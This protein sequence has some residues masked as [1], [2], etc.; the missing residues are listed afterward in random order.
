MSSKSAERKADHPWV[1][2][3]RR[4]FLKCSALLGGSLAA[5]TALGRFIQD[6][7]NGSAWAASNAVGMKDNAYV[8]H[9]PENQIHSVCQQC[10]TNCG[11]KVKIVDGRVEKIDGNPYSPWTLTPHIPYDTPLAEAATIEGGICPKGQAGIQALYDPYR[12]VKVL[13][14]AGKRGENKW[15]TIPFED[16]V[17]EIV[18]GGDLFGEGPVEGLKDICVLRDPGLLKDLEDDAALVASKKMTPEAFK[19]KHAA[20]L[21]YLI[22][23]DHPDLGPKN[24]QF[25]LN[26]GRLKA[27]RSDLLKRFVGSALGTVNAHGHTT[28]CQGSLY[29]TCKAMSDQFT[30]GKFTGGSKFYWQADTGNAEFIIFVGANPY[31]ANYGPPLRV[32]KITEGMIDGR[33]KIAVIDPRCSK[34]ASRAW[35]WLPVR[36]NGVAAVAMGMI[37][38]IIENNRYNA[39]YLANAN[40]AAATG[41]GEPTWTQAAWLVKLRPD[42]SPGPYLRGS[43]L[44]VAV[45]KRPRKESGEW[46]FDP[47]V[48]LREGAPVTLD[49]N[50]EKTP[51]KGDLLV[52]A[53]VNGIKVKSVLQIYRETAAEKP[54]G[55]WAE[56]AGLK[57]KDIAD[58]AREFTSH[59]RKAAVDMHRGVSQ[60]TSG[61]YNVLSWM[62]VNVLIGNHDY[63]GGLAKA[64]GHDLLGSKQG[65][66][67]DLG[68]QS[69][70]LRPWGISII[71][72]EAV[73]D[74]T[75]LF[76]G[77]P[78]RRVWYPFSSD[79]YQEVIPSM[80]DAYPY[81]IKALLLYMGSPVYALPAGHK[82]VEILSDPKK[83]PLIFASDIVVGET[84]M[85]ADYIFPDLTYLERWE[86]SGAHPSVTPKVA[87]FRQPAAPP[88]T[89]TVTVFGEQ[90]PLS[91]ESLVLAVAERLKLA[92]FGENG[93][94]PGLH[95]KREEDLYLRMVANVAYG[96][97]P[98]GSEKV[99]PASPEEIQIFEKARR[100][101]PPTVFDANRWKAAVG[102]EMWPCVVTV[103][104]RGGRFQGYAQAYKDGKLTNRYG[105][106]V[107]LYFDKFVTTKHSMTGEPYIGH[108]V[109]IDGPCDCTGKKIEDE[110]RGFDM[111]LITYKT[112]SQTKS[113]TGGNYWLQALYPENTIEISSLD[114]ARLNLHPGDR[115]RVTSAS[116]EEG[117][118]DLGHGRRNPMIGHIRVLEGLRPGVVAFSLGHGHW[119]YGAGSVVIDGQT[120][121]A[122]PRRATGVHANAA[123]RVDPVLKNTGLVDTVGGSAV[124]YQSQVKLV[125]V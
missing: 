47:F 18:E 4:D 124:F 66:P 44:G 106:L 62:M 61:F 51:V 22:D 116:N 54:L 64:T 3:E 16:A 93:F 105:K 6:Q 73:Y 67:F 98:D 25:C 76:E 114:A 53:E 37:Q 34:T 65:M 108:A 74:K 33:M 115:V 52:D 109:F 92:G 101:L 82:L 8:H 99:K 95:L 69:G 104:N 59:G 14:R 86:F 110:A 38:W 17:R 9:L 20:N 35:K 19:T 30:E 32:Q 88:Q 48:V 27:G 113:R 15:K 68:K 43:D 31:E 117:I 100:H 7:G 57:E 90:M 81:P 87:P 42:G 94:G 120:V 122:D 60:H 13:K 118:W 70:K 103:L 56:I 11:I 28:V 50:D 107:G 102:E 36:P 5:A 2:M 84:T 1:E 85:Y 41:D 12:L 72:H 63:M 91:L 23:P 112:I 111:T 97:K 125:K 77:F 79:I 78:S 26:W 80:G 10:N 89:D 55:Q 45:E 71:R 119:A 24:N 96:D 39:R 58:L 121:T 83:I 46:D 49:P 21:Q 75:T 40:K 123:M 29:F